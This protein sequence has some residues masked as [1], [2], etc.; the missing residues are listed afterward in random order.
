MNRT[1]WGKFGQNF[2]TPVD[3]LR[4]HMFK[5]YLAQQL[6]ISKGTIQT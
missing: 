3:H 5:R 2:K 4:K 1:I 6:P